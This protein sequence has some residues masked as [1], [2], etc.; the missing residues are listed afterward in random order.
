M[1]EALTSGS[2]GLI[3]P[4]L[5]TIWLPRGVPKLAF[6]NLTFLSLSDHP[7]V[8]NPPTA[9]KRL[10]G[11]AGRSRGRPAQRLDGT[12]APTVI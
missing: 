7:G 6:Q 11:R 3:H 5:F 1:P 8:V 9:S 12:I 10:V 2:G 4:Q